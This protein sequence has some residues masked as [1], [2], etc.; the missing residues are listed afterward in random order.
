MSSPRKASGPRKEKGR[1]RYSLR[2]RPCGWPLCFLAARTAEPI[3]GPAILRNQLRTVPLKVTAPHS[4]SPST[5]AFLVACRGSSLTPGG[6]RSEAGIWSP[7]PAF[8]GHP[9]RA[10]RVRGVFGEKKNKGFETVKKERE[11]RLTIVTDLP[12]GHPNQGRLEHL[13]CEWDHR[14]GRCESLEPFPI[15]YRKLACTWCSKGVV[16]MNGQV[17][18][19]TGPVNLKSDSFPFGS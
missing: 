16:R 6:H 5:L 1:L 8:P 4:P 11:E 2:S 10:E 18:D 14:D 3:P 12:A 7:T 17:I 15:L 19:F 13:S 9:A